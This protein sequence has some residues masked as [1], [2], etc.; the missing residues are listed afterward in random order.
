M[1]SFL[2]GA[3][4]HGF[5]GAFSTDAEALAFVQACGW[6]S[7]GTGLGDPQTGMCFYDTNYL[8]LKVYSGTAWQWSPFKSGGAGNPNAADG[9]AGTPGN[10]GDTYI[11]T[12][13]VISY[14]NVTG[15]ATGW[16]AS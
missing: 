8:V 10:W 7:L 5:L 16:K 2:Y 13:N 1:A 14:V 12:S 3:P 9:G 4:S 11:D 15:T 6:D